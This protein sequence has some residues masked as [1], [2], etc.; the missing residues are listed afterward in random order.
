MLGSGL[1]AKLYLAAGVALLGSYLYTETRGVVFGSS[2]ERA[3]LPAEAR[4]SRGYRAHG[5]WFV[6]YHGGK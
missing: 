2:D 3:S 1:F 5:F 6:G 4:S